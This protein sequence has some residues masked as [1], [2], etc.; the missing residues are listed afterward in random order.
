VDR[1]KAARY[2]LNAGDVNTVIQAAMGGATASTVLEGDRQFG[3]VVR[4]APEFRDTIEKIR[5]IKAGY[6]TGS[7][8][9]AYVPL[10]E[11]ATI[12]LDTGASWI[13]HESTERFIPVKFSVRGRDLGSTVAEAQARL[14][15]NVKLPSGY[16]MIWAGEFED[17][18]L[19]KERLEFIVPISL[20][21]I[22]GLLYCLFNSMLLCLLTLAGIPFAIAGGV[23]A[24]YVAGLTFSISAAI[25]FVSLFGV[26]VMNGILLITYY[27]Q[28]M[29]RGLRP[30][31]AMYRA[32]STRMRPLL[33]TS[34]SACIGLFPAAISTGIG[35]QVQR[36][37]ATVIVGG[38]LVGPIMLLIVVPALK[39]V[40]L[41]RAE[42]TPT[43]APIQPEI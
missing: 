39:M 22:L 4:Y 17:L 16:R 30:S 9:N 24:L 29:L 1:A 7:G 14:A 5:N 21:L 43:D 8:A 18:Q 19:A 26:S 23:L 2:G 20:V 40:F 13:Y 33:M 36:P 31:E 34:L 12:T 6:T 38:M 10:S 3:L 35:S 42:N 25:G 32:A 11:L 27:N 28:S 15:K 37:L 41:D